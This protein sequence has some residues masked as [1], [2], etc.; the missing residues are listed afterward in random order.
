MYSLN[1]ENFNLLGDSWQI[2]YNEEPLACKLYSG[3]SYNDFMSCNNLNRNLI[4]RFSIAIISGKKSLGKCRTNLH[5][6]HQN[7]KCVI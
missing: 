2:P 6:I 5:L 4:V 3:N 7:D 1:E